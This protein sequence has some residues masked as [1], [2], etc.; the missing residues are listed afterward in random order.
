MLLCVCILVK[1]YKIRIIVGQTT[2]AF[3][4]V[5]D[6]TKRVLGHI[7]VSDVLKMTITEALKKERSSSSKWR[8]HPGERRQLRA[9]INSPFEFEALIFESTVPLISR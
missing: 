7:P 8:D 1:Y 9:W 5:A 2:A 3:Y 4:I 6:T